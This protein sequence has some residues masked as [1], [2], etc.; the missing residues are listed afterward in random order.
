M[1]KQWKRH[2]G[3]A[4]LILV[5]AGLALL[6]AGCG[7]GE[8]GSGATGT[9]GGGSSNPDVAAGAPEKLGAGEGEV[10]LIAWAGYVED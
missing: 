3:W 5:V 4:A 7:G 2:A 1:S 8:E 6:A 9:G 10:N